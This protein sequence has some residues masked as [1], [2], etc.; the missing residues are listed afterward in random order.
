VPAGTG[1]DT[2][3]A[4]LADKLLA[5]R[6][7]LDNE[8]ICAKVSNPVASSAAAL[9]YLTFAFALPVTGAQEPAQS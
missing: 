1:A 5:L 3:K 7:L 6:L 4:A 2:A 9:S 8:D